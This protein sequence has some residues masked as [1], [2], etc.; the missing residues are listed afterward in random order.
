MFDTRANAST[1]RAGVMNPTYWRR[2]RSYVACGKA[3]MSEAVL[4]E[5]PSPPPVNWID[6]SIRH[7]RSAWYVGIV[8]ALYFVAST[9]LA[10]AAFP[11]VTLLLAVLERTAHAELWIRALAC[12]AAIGLGFFLAGVTLLLILPIY[13]FLL[14][15]RVRPFRGGYFTFAALN[16]YVHN[17]LLYLA[18]YTFLPFVTFTPFGIWFLRAMGMRIGK[19]VTFNTEYV[20]DACMITVGD[21][22]VIGGSVRL[23]AHYAGGGHLVIAPVRIGE[24]ATI[25]ENATVMGN[26]VVGRGAVIAP[27]AVL[28][29]GTRVQAGQHWPERS[30]GIRPS[31]TG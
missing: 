1:S 11:S 2:L 14:P 31:G 9:A 3:A 29:P 23:F 26:V 5:A 27:H 24:G 12:S 8:C 20:S 6:R 28:L 10:L 17:G 7:F 21:D 13:N 15:T 19:R 30:R 18:R 16:W 4:H 22:A 25:G